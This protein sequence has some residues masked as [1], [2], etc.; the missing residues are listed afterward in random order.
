M[1]NQAPPLVTIVTPSFN[2]A[3]FIEE[4]INSV[5]NQSYDPIEYLVIDGGS[6]DGSV[7]IL[8]R[9]EGRLRWISEPD[10]GQGDAINK[11]FRL[12][13]GSLLGWLNADDLLYPNAV[14]TIVTHFRT[15]PASAFVYGDALAIDRQGHA[16][17]RRTHVAP[18]NFDL[19]LHQGDFIVQPSAFW[20]AELWQKIGELDLAWRYVLD[21][22]YWLRVAQKYDL[23]YIPQFLSKERLYAS[24]K[25]F[26][27]GLERINELEHL[28]QRYGGKGIPSR[29]RAEAAAVYLHNAWTALKQRHWGDTRNSVR[30]AII[31]NN[32]TVK[33]LLYV[34]AMIF[35]GN[36]GIP[37]LRL[38]MNLVRSRL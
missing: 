9:Y 12:A 24:A 28:A 23:A 18:C 37:R 15:N 10:Q 31:L 32:A 7:E 34:L 3:A 14:S 33:L 26:S 8:K 19:L 25:T 2:Q 21:Y 5:L 22:D 11:G 20:R 30:R 38:W 13:K 6:T 4:T 29:F 27:G 16:Y 1:L 36:Q 17:G 35:W